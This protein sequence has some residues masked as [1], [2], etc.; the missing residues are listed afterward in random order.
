MGCN[1]CSAIEDSLDFETKY[2]A[3]GLY[4]FMNKSG[5]CCINSFLQIF[6]HNQLITD[7]I[8]SINQKDIN[9]D[10]NEG[11]LINAIN[12]LLNEIRNN[13]IILSP[14]EI[15]EAMICINEEYKNNSADANDFICDFISELINEIPKKEEFKINIPSNEIASQALIKLINRFYKKNNSIFIELFFGNSMIEYYCIKGHLLDIKF[16]TFI[17]ID[18]GLYSFK[19]KKTIKIEELLDYSFNSIKNQDFTKMCKICGD[20]NNCYEKHYIYSLPKILILYISRNFENCFFDNKIEFKNEINMEK[21]IKYNDKI[22][23]K[24][25]LFGIIQNIN[26]HYNSATINNDDNNWYFFNDDYEPST[27]NKDLNKFNPVFLFYNLT[28]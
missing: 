13:V 23:T 12:K 16:N 22:S 14:I 26:G 3:K 19:D 10:Q 5:E 25:K 9:K 17:T 15:K 27:V 4:R 18:L 24:Y 21:Y 6:L 28:Y 20:N 7:V 2:N 1:I 8:N 11:K